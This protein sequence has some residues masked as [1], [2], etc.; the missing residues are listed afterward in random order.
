[1]RKS[2]I[3]LVVL[4]VVFCAAVAFA[5]QKEMKVGF[6]YVSPIGDAGWSYA[7]DVGR[8]AVEAM[9][10]KGTI[11]LIT[12]DDQRKGKCIISVEDT[13]P[14]IPQDMMNELFKPYFTKKPSGSGLGLA[15]AHRIV[16]EHSGHIMVSNLPDGGA[17]FT[18]ELPLS[19][20]GSK[21]ATVEKTT[22][23]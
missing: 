19:Q 17:A 9:D 20:R 12:E 2:G 15:I 3:F 10:G 5:A 21:P 7:H 16:S 18:I 23:F 8:N 14:G 6:V 22:T 4:V 11:I 13:G 1:M